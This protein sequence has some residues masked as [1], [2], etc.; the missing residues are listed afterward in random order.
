MV[1]PGCFEIALSL[2]GLSLVL[3]RSGPLPVIARQ[4][5]SDSNSNCFVRDSWL[6]RKDG[7]VCVIDASAGKVSPGA[8]RPPKYPARPM[9]VLCLFKIYANKSFRW[10][11]GFVSEN[12]SLCQ[13]IG[14]T[15]GCP[16]Y[17]TIRR[18]MSFLDE[19][20]LR[21]LNKRVL[22]ELKKSRLKVTL[23]ATGVGTKLFDRWLSH[24]TDR[25]KDFVKL[26]AAIDDRGAAH[27]IA[28]TD[29]T[30]ND[31]IV[32]PYLINDID[33]R[34]GVVRADAAQ[35]TSPGT[36]SSSSRT[37]APFPISSPSPP[38]HHGEQGQVRLEALALQ[39]PEGQGGVPEGVQPAEKSR[40][41]LL[42]VQETV[43]AGQEPHRDDAAQGGLGE[44]PHPEHPDRDGRANRGGSE[45]GGLIMCHSN[46]LG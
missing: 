5:C 9:V 8:G 41:V 27:A 19:S 1:L 12:G 23:D 16:S 11:D 25:S 46:Y 17:E 28:I 38:L 34:L 37:W 33:A 44:D 36:T 18:T 6:A 31:S 3:A 42:K 22:A 26:H 24:P 39:V 10:V 43:R 30:T 13:E 14:L 45:G 35:D 29:G 20:Y 21:N 32:F 40:G 2:S 7:V 15:K 4:L